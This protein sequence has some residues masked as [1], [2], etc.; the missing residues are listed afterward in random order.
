MLAQQRR[1]LW[2]AI[3]PDHDLVLVDIDVPLYRG[4]D[5][6]AQQFEEVGLAAQRGLDMPLG[7]GLKLERELYEWLQKTDDAREG[8][9]AFTQKRPPQWKGR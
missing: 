5:F 6:R 4:E 7:D 2:S 3:H 8:A 1:D 9:L